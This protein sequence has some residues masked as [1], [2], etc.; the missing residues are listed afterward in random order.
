MAGEGAGE[1]GGLANDEPG[2]KRIGVQAWSTDARGRRT[3]VLRLFLTRRHR[4]RSA[5]RTSTTGEGGKLGKTAGYDHEKERRRTIR[6]R[7]RK[8]RTEENNRSRVSH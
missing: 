3:D 6:L 7:P 4:I 8:A 5:L 2:R 1:K